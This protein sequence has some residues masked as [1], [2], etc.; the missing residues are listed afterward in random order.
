MQIHLKRYDEWVA[1]ALRVRKLG[2]P[3]VDFRT[4]QHTHRIRP[5]ASEHENLT[6]LA[7]DWLPVLEDG[8]A[9][10]EGMIHSAH[11][12]PGKSQSIR[13]DGAG[14]FVAKDHALHH[15]DRPLIVIGGAA[16]LYH[17]L[18]DYLPRLLLT[19]QIEDYDDWALLVNDDLAP[20]QLESLRMLDIDESRLIRLGRQDAIRASRACVPRLLADFTYCHPKTPDL[21]NRAFAPEPTLPLRRV[22]LSRADAANRRFVNEPA[23]VSLLDRHGFETVVA[24]SL[25]FRQQMNLFASAGAIV[26]AHGAGLG[27]LVSARPGTQVYEISS[28]RQRVTSMEN[29][30]DMRK[31][32]HRYVD[33]QVV[34]D[35]SPIPLLND[36]EVDLAQME[37]ALVEGLRS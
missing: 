33:A 32:V 14:G 19:D 36:W 21:L 22:Y 11:M 30:A 8:S 10:F 7:G 1:Q 35:W 25:T 28:P 2:W 16:N 31:L 9:T 6:I 37:Q 34:S 23:L 3:G 4:T 13:A 24:S 27:N 17:W 29:I 12:Y 20:F 18:I 5:V 15:T 26:S